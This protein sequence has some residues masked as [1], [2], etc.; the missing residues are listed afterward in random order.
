[1]EKQIITGLMAIMIGLAGWNLKTTHDLSIIVSNMQVSHAD[2]DAIQDMKMAIQRLELLLL[3]DQWLS[4]S[5]LST[6]EQLLSTRP[7]GSQILTNAY[8]LQNG[9]L[10]NDQSP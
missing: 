7:S 4:S 1:M 2:K 10:T 3:Q 9:C 8:T 5:L 6:W